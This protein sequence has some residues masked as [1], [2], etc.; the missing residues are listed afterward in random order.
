MPR[1]ILATVHPAALSHN[2]ARVR[3]AAPDARVWAIVKANAYGHGIERVFDALRSADG[4]ALLDL[5]EAQRLRALDWRGPILLLEGCFELRDLELCSRLG[6]W[7]A[8]HCDEQIDMLATH[9]TQVPH[10]VFLKMNSG[11]NRLGFPPER[12]RAAW[13]RLNALPQVEEISLMT[14]FSDAD[15]PKGIAAQLQAFEAVTHDLP[16]ERTLSNSAAVLR[17]GALVGEKSDWV[18]PGIVVYGSAPDFPEHSAADWGLQPT[19]TL[20][21]KIIGVQHLVAGDTVGYG[22]SFTAEGPLRIGVVACGYADGYPRHCTTGTP[23]LVNGV[24][25]RMVGRVSM[26][27][28]TV[29]LTPVPE[30]GMGAEVTLWGRSSSGALQPIDEVA[31]AAGTVAY[32]LMCAV[33]PRVPVVAD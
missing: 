4:F 33:A 21:A 24:R 15:G 27:M 25:T 3:A 6:L 22:S 5:A 13:T 26:D 11:M 12:Y 16:G 29:D 19:M 14:H 32:E 28:L 18:R 10:R 31:Q 17:H 8:I 20:A 1:P 7:H 23:L 9:K 2:L 30:A